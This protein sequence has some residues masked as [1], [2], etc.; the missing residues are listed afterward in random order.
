MSRAPNLRNA[1]CCAD[2]SYGDVKHYLVD[3]LKHTDTID[4]TWI[5]D[6]YK[7]KDE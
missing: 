7:E 4:Q 3:C 6:D 5:C 1:K 2:C